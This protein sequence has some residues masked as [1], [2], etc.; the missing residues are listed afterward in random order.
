MKKKLNQLEATAICGNDISSSCLFVSALAIVYSGQ[1]AWISLLVVAFVLFLF[2]KIYGEVVGALPLNGGA[3]NALLNTTKKSTASL[4]AALTVLSYMATAVISASEAVKYAYSIWCFI[5]VLPVTIFLMFCFMAL[6]IIGIGESSK[7][8]IVIFLFHLFSLTLL[9]AFCIVF[10]AQNGFGTLLS[11]YKVPLEGSVFS[12]LFLG[13]SAAM[14]GISGFESSANYVEEQK[15]GVFPKTLRN[16][17][18]VVTVFNPLIAFLALAII[19]LNVIESNQDALLSHMADVSGGNWLSI[20]VG[21]DAALVLSGAVLTSFVGVGGLM[22]RMALDRILPKFLLKKNKSGSSYLIYTLFYILCVSILLATKG[23]LAKLAGVYTI[24]FLSVMVLFGLGNMMLKINR[25][26]LPRPERSSWVGL[27]IAILAVITAMAGNIILNPS[28]LGIFTEYLIPTL[29]VVFFMLYRT[30]IFRGFLDILSFVFPDKGHL[31][32]TLNVQTKKLL[33]AINKQQFVFFTN[34]DD[35]ATLNK[36]MLYIK[37]NEPTRILKIVA[38]VNEGHIMAPKLKE[39]IEVLDRAYP[40]IHIQ[41]VEEVGVF[42]PAKIKEL[43]K[44]WGIPTN[45]MFIGSPGDKFPYKIQE[46]GDVR[47]II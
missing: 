24:A 31:F 20:L 9:C 45:F 11:N 43:S 33:A 6:V 27:I 8:A 5:P 21:I 41:C 36:V 39:D 17:W 25:D 30:Y 42:G 22:E 37:N 4:A 19:P 3:Y 18:V 10:F 2:R 47:L 40:D 26:K 35:V 29:L 15:A 38:V 13:F 14:L 16:M 46:L 12:A 34:H 44:R 7:V 32:K 28:Y 1:Y 23:N